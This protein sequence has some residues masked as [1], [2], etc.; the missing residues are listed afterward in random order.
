MRGQDAKSDLAPDDAALSGPAKRSSFLCESGQADAYP[1]HNINLVAFLP[2]ADLGAVPGIGLNDAWGWVDP[3]TGQRWA[4]VGREDGTAFV[5]ITDPSALRYAG[6]LRMPTSAQSNVWRDIKVDGTW[7]FIVADG[8]ANRQGMHGMQVFDLTRLRGANGSP[9]S[10]SA[11]AHYTDFAVA[12]NVVINEESD[13]AYA[14]GARLDQ[15]G[16]NAGLHMIDIADPLN[17]RFLGCF[18]DRGTGRAGLGYT[19]DAQCVTYRGPD[20]QHQGREICVGSNETALSIVDVTD[21]SAPRPLA[22]ASYPAASYVHQ[23][24]FSEDQRLFIQNDELD[25]RQFDARTHTYIWDVEDL[26]DPVLLTDFVSDVTS[27]DHNL[28]VRG[29]LVYQANY[30]SGLRVMDISD[31]E[32]PFVAGFFDTRP[33]DSAVN[34]TGA[35]TAWPYPDSDLVIISSRGEGLFVVRPSA[36]IGSRFTAFEASADEGM[37]ELSWQF[38]RSAGLTRYQVIDH[39]E[40]GGE[41]ILFSGTDVP[42]SGSESIPVDEGIYHVQMVGFSSEGGRVES[43]VQSVNV[44][45][46]THLFEAPWPNPVGAIARTTLAV[47]RGQRVRV[48]VHDALGRERTVLYNDVLSDD[49]QLRLDV[50]VSSWPAGVYYLNLTGQHFQESAPFTVV[51]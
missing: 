34:F 45:G 36:I 4:L 33:D 17:P 1:C 16:C 41:T 46:G 18:A 19:H 44:I 23:G 14:V 28:Y 22:R 12:H 2:K 32:D 20:R 10:F 27:T 35:W 37:I 49:R 24:W 40:N 31:P 8:S 21:A 26:D 25:E 15:H 11:D 3:L 29:D 9:V 7:A 5:E 47:S 6:E 48:S 43:A 38:N 50:D 13:R 30:S 39:D 42:P 51:H